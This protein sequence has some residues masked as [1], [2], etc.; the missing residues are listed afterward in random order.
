MLFYYGCV[1]EVEKTWWCSFLCY[2]SCYDLG[3]MSLIRS[4]SLETC[5]SA[6]LFVSKFMCQHAKESY[7]R[8]RKP[9]R[10]TKEFTLLLNA[11][12]WSSMLPI[13]RVK[14]R[15][16]NLTAKI[17]GVIN[18]N[19][20]DPFAFYHIQE[21]AWLLVGL[22]KKCKKNSFSIFPSINKNQ[23]SNLGLRSNANILEFSRIFSFKMRI[24]KFE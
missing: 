24:F 1:E 10:P 5:S 7:C 2:R 15:I 19:I 20:M 6:I 3:R 4:L 9:L 13:L 18:I 8:E 11:L 17:L 12:C 16:L 22:M 21:S 14:Y 23:Y